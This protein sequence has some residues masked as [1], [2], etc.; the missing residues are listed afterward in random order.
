MVGGTVCMYAY[1]YTSGNVK[2]LGHYFPIFKAIFK[3]NYQSPSNLPCFQ[4]LDDF[5]QLFHCLFSDPKMRCFHLPEL[6]ESDSQETFIL[7]QFSSVEGE[8]S[9][10]RVLIIYSES[11]E[12]HI[13]P[14]Q[15]PELEK[16]DGDDDSKT[17]QNKTKFFKNHTELTCMLK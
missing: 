6:G 16:H 11:Y 17:H 9:G 12:G 3:N 13:R 4:S 5:Q 15:A 10:R 8:E 1:T 14:S 7:A 2:S